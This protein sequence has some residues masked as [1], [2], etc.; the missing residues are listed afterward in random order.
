MPDIYR[1]DQWVTKAVSVLQNLRDNVFWEMRARGISTNGSIDGDRYANEMY[2]AYCAAKKAI[3]SIKE[4]QSLDVIKNM[5]AY[6]YKAMPTSLGAGN[7]FENQ[8]RGAIKLFEEAL[9][10]LEDDESEEVVEA[11]TYIKYFHYLGSC[12]KEK[13]FIFNP[14]KKRPRV[15]MKTYLG[16]IFCVSHS[17]MNVKGT[18]RKVFRAMA[19]HLGRDLSIPEDQQSLDSQLPLLESFRNGS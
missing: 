13:G 19:E 12:R 2:G 5:L 10:I 17:W 6:N 18:R 11:D 9:R 16:G 14:K 3:K 15:I 1:E 7:R 4:G 8:C